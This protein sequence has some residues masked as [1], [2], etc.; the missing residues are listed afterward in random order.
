METTKTPAQQLI[1]TKILDIL[2]FM[3]LTGKVDSELVEGVLRVDV[4]TSNDSLFVDGAADPLLAL[5]H[6][7]RVIFKSELAEASASLILN[8]GDFQVR[9]KTNL[10][11]IANEAAQKAIDTQV[12]VPLRPM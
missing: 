6:L 1:E 12:D 7:L 9:Q 8:I 10:E 4:Q 5:Q 11:E 3:G 2:K